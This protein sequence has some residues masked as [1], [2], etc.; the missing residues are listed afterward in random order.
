MAI[1]YQVGNRAKIKLVTA[2]KPILSAEKYDEIRQGLRPTAKKQARLLTYLMTASPNWIAQKEIIDAT[3]VDYTT[4][5]KA[6]TNGWI[7][8]VKLNNIAYQS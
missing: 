1:N 2:V 4:L 3:A 6:E 7:Q 5:K 8:K